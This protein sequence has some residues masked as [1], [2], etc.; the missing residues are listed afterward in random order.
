[1]T[2]STY[3]RD[4][5]TVRVTELADG[6][7]SIEVD[8]APGTVVAR[9]HWETS[10]PLELIEAV[11]DVKGAAWVCDEIMRDEDPGYVRRNLAEVLHAYAG[12]WQASVS[13]ILDFGC[14]CGSSTVALA[15]HFPDAE[16]VGVE[17]LDEHV[18][19]ARRRLAHHGI[20]GAQVLLSP[21]GDS[22]PEG[23]GSFDLVC[24]SAVY[25]HLLPDE[26]PVIL[27]LLDSVTALEGTL[28]VFETPDRR[29]PI[30]THTSGL[31]LVNYLPDRIAFAAVRRFSPRVD[32]DL[33][34]TDLLREGVRGAT[35][36]EIERNLRASGGNW[37]RLSPTAPGLRHQSQIWYRAAAERLSDRPT[38]RRAVSVVDRLRLP[39]SPYLTLAYR[40]LD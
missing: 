4:D 6:R 12:P 9:T 14:G 15:S 20:D 25:E 22:V 38:L 39:V 5:G 26:R 32:N 10:Y 3:E 13:R 40:K 33:L 17:L 23:I 21:S 18:D 19:L 34:D 36:G 28:L 16:I 31:P 35:L 8:P 1:V 37:Q 2:T 27:G 29:F 11:L 24:L 30:E 7:R